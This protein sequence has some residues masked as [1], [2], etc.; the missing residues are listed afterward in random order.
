MS[1]KAYKGFNKDMTCR[2]FQ[3]EEGKEY[4][5]DK[6][7]VCETGFHACEYPLDCFSYYS[8]NV[9]VYHEVEQDG[10]ISRSDGDS[11]VASSKIKIGASINIAGIVK[12]AIE[13]TTKRTN[14]END[15]TG[16]YGASSA[17]GNYGAS[18]ATG[19]YG[20]SSATG[21]YG[22]SSATGYKGA[23]SATVNYGASSATGYCSVS[24][25]T[26]NYGASSA[27][28]YKGASSATGD[29]GASSATGDYGASSAT[30]DYGASSA[31]GNYGAS[32]AT[33]YKGASSA[34]GN[35]GASSATGDY[36]ASSATGYCSVSSATGYCSVSSAECENSIAVAWGYHGK[37]K[38]VI[39]SYLV[40][41][42]WEGDENNYW[43][44][45]LWSL[46]GAKMVR[47]D[48]KIIKENTFYT[49]V[50]GEIEEV[51]DE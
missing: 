39:G 49:M 17:T 50:N 42:D 10:E 22:A 32:S 14:K 28:G 27:T 13:Y 31:T 33:G 24:S 6:V 18:S 21:N 34:T 45:E 30:G 44:P 7:E 23:S 25:A 1:I 46:K 41:A 8:P 5:T 16:D 48:G 51:E 40:L 4:E 29:K 20:A 9:S 2:G 11:K 35:Y 47:V 43:T 19:D 38:G 15:A 36:G 3:Y 37:T 12:A 26:G